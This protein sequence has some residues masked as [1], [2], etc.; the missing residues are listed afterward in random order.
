MST[1]TTTNTANLQTGSVVLPGD[2]LLDVSTYADSNK[3]I[4]FGPGTKRFGDKIIITKCGVLK[5]NASN[6]YYVDNHQIRYVPS[7]RENVIGVVTKKGGDEAVVDIGS[8]E[9]AIVDLLSFEGATKRN[10]PN[11]KPGDLLYATI[12]T[13][14]K[15]MEAE[16][17]CV[18]KYGKS[19]GFGVL[20]ADGFV[21]NASLE[22]CRRLLLPNSRILKR[23]GK[24]IPF[25]IA[26]GAN[27]RIWLKSKTLEKTMVLVQALIVLEFATTN[28]IESMCSELSTVN[29]M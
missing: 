25:E 27:G 28:E 9:P 5:Q 1:P 23:L 14:C 11:L 19:V 2:I 20:P 18:D 24:S 10:K 21:F 12:L 7:R 26:V 17:V 4:I 6:V 8:S 16:L 3:K 29:I 15:D 22:Y 13:A